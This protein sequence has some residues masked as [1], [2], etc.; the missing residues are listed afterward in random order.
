MSL[1]C[2]GKLQYPEETY[3]GTGRTCKLNAGAS[4]SALVGIRS[5]DP[6]AARRKAPPYTIECLEQWIRVGNNGGN[7]TLPTGPNN[8]GRKTQLQNANAKSLQTKAACSPGKTEKAWTEDQVA[9]FKTRLQRL[10]PIMKLPPFWKNGLVKVQ[11][12]IF[13]WECKLLRSD[14]LS[15]VWWWTLMCLCSR[16]EKK[17]LPGTLID[18]LE[19]GFSGFQNSRNHRLKKSLNP[20]RPGFQQQPC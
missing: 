3:A 15:I 11:E 14:S 16:Q 1:G 5:N 4:A 7:V 10:Y 20:V 6:S 8:K 18:L 12:G 9:A 2:G 13:L 17:G 19:R